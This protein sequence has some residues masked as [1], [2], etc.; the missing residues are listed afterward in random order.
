MDAATVLCLRDNA[1][2]LLRNGV[3]VAAWTIPEVRA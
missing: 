3:I 2:R 1:L